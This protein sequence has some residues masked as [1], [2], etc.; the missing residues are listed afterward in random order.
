LPPGLSSIYVDSNLIHYR[1][2]SILGSHGSTPQ[3]NKEVL[4]MLARKAMDVSDLIT[5]T[6]SLDSIEEAFHF[7][8]N[9]YG[10]HVGIYP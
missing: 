10:M 4:A 5:H 7:K 9:R 1:E 3:D 6:Y 2:I 8:E